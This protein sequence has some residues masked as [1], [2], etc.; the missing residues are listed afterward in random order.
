MK[1]PHPSR[2][3]THYKEVESRC[4]LPRCPKSRHR[5]GADPAQREWV[6]WSGGGDGEEMRP[7]HRKVQ[8]HTFLSISGSKLI[9][10]V[11]L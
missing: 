7:T 6:E 11:F 2:R 3:L 9:G 8:E 10:E 5:L 4:S 1:D